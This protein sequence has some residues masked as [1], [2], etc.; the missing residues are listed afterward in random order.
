MK[1]R[2]NLH[3]VGSDSLTKNKVC[4]NFFYRSLRHHRSFQSTLNATNWGYFFS[5][6]TK[7]FF[8]QI[9]ITLL[10]CCFS[11][12]RCCCHV[13]SSSQI[14]IF[15][16]SWSHYIRDHFSILDS[17]ASISFKNSLN[18]RW[19]CVFFFFPAVKGGASFAWINVLQKHIPEGCLCCLAT[20]CVPMA[21]DFPDLK[22]SFYC[23][24]PQ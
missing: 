10:S 21:A 1:D 11:W 22:F 3:D 7:S 8:W 18:Q 17:Q 9:K 19:A 2:Q 14:R 12:V 5:L 23:E 15:L 16:L 24:V 20:G 13:P 6:P 4:C